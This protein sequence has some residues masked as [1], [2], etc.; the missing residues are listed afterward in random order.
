MKQIEVEI[1]T[2]CG[3]AHYG[4]EKTDEKQN[5]VKI[6]DTLAEYLRPMLDDGLNMETIHEL[7]AQMEESDSD[8]ASELSKMYYDIENLCDDMM[9]EYCLEN[10]KDYY[11]DDNL[12]EYYDKDVEEGLFIPSCNSIDE[13][14]E[15]HKDEY[16]DFDENYDTIE[17]D[18]YNA[19]WNEYLDW[20]DHLEDNYE[21]AVRCFG[22]DFSPMDRCLDWDYE[23]LSISK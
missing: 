18:Y 21:R 22:E 10:D 7:Q 15:A 17:E 23:I 3:W 12:S 11:D 20:V 16:E 8:L 6:S 9:M 2:D 1:T 19:K 13:F 5:V 14:Y 4:G